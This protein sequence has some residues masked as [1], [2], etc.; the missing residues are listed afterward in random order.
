MNP[1]E[2]SGVMIDELL[3]VEIRVA[4]RADELSKSANWNPRDSSAPWRQAELEVLGGASNAAV[5]P[6]VQGR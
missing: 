5:S 2:L 6:L 1:P 4:R 3:D